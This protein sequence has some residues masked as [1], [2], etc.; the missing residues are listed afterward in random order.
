[1]CMF[2]NPKNDADHHLELDPDMGVEDIYFSLSLLTN[3][4]P[5][6][7]ISLFLSTGDQ[8]QGLPCVSHICFT[9][10]LCLHV[11]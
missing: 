11:L 5:L 1:M 7:L 9:T 10:D 8:T 4:S 3:P 6:A 2:V